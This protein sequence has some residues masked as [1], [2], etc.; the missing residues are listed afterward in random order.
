MA[1]VIQD[2]DKILSKIIWNY[3]LLHLIYTLHSCL[4]EIFAEEQ[5]IDMWDY[6]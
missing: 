5:L 1:Q 4:I 3:L 2:S 6:Q